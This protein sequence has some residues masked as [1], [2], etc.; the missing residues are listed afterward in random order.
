MSSSGKMLTTQALSFMIVDNCPVTSNGG[1][2][3]GQC[4]E[5]MLNLAGQEFHFDI[6]SDAMSRQQYNTFFNG[7]TDGK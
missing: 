2:Y 3:C 6:A 5:G 7:A 1:G 4:R